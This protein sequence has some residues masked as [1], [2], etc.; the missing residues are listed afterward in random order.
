MDRLALCLGL[1]LSIVSIDALAA[2][3]G[4]VLGQPPSAHIFHYQARVE[5]DLATQTLT[6]VVLIHYK[7][8]VNATAHLRL[9]VGD[10]TIESAIE[11]Q[12]QL[13]FEKLGQ[14]LTITLAEPAIS[15]ASPR[16]QPRVVTLR[17]R[18]APKQ[19]LTFLTD[20]QQIF[21][22]FSTSHWLPCH[23]SPAARATLALT[24]VVPKGFK[25]VA[26]GNL[27]A[28]R[29]LPS[30][31]IASEWLQNT[32]TPCYTFGFATGDFLEVQD[33]SATPILRFLVP[34]SFTAE[35]T[36]TIFSQTRAM[37]AFYED[38]AGVKYPDTVYTQVLVS[39]GAAQEMSG[40]AV[41]GQNYGKRVLQDP[42]AIWLGAHELSHQW[43]GNRV[44]NH[45]W[46]E[47]WLNEGIATFMNAAY[48]EHQD[49]A[50]AY[51]SHINGAK[52]KYEAIRAAGKDK[53]L[54]FAD[55]DRPSREDRSLVYDK[56]AY[57][58]HLLRQKLGD[59]A[60]W[61]GIQRYTRLNWGRAVSTT[62]FSDAMEQASGLLLG[63]FFDEWV[64]ARPVPP[65]K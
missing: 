21:T 51:L 61:Q 60:F 3:P 22:A 10:L 32:A 43:W 65:L 15:I 64:L 44:T 48:F 50:E 38:K 30:G 26:N 45:A 23:D 46:T 16:D 58:L 6:G 31:K 53:S 35:E 19:G 17:Y 14:L 40:F 47:F 13:A 7:L 63:D 12:T 33:G 42:K 20:A 57:L 29:L 62:D 1:A 39:G 2:A 8:P 24:V 25:T 4:E 37:I 49:G 11:G 18:G 41:M 52:A 34:P 55:W 28:Q 56:G 36:Q 5:P 27:V 54:V 59:K 9:N